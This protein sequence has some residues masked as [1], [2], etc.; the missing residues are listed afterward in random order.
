M[1][2]LECRCP[3]QLSQAVA[4]RGSGSGLACSYLPT[5]KLDLQVESV[6]VLA[7]HLPGR[8]C[9]QTG[10]VKML[11]QHPV[12]L[13]DLLGSFHLPQQLPQQSKQLLA[14]EVWPP[15]VDKGTDIQLIQRQL[16]YHAPCKSAINGIGR[17]RVSKQ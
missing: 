12:R 7:P 4:R 6:E 3:L 5:S 1:F 13:T 17:H 10:P 9:L 2:G 14:A 8:P 16:L 15:I 11:S